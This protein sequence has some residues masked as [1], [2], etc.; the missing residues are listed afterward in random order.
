MGSGTDPQRRADDVIAIGSTGRTDDIGTKHDT[1][2]A[3][4]RNGS[5]RALLA[6]SLLVVALRSS[7]G[8][9][10]WT[11]LL[12]AALTLALLGPYEWI[13]H[14]CLLHAPVDSARMQRLGIGRGHVEHHQDPFEIRWLMLCWIEALSCWALLG[15]QSALLALP[16]AVVTDASIAALALSFWSAATLG[17]LHYEW[18]HLL[19][20]TRYRCRTR[21]YRAL[22]RHHRL[23]HFRNER[24]WLGVTARTGDRLR[25]TM[26]D[27]SGV[28][29]SA[30]A[31]T[32]RPTSPPLTATMLADVESLLYD[33]SNDTRPAWPTAVDAGDR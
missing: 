20:H 9:F 32:L 2:R 10:H 26:P 6:V 30:T 31:K 8:P 17:L 19:V 22:Q 3:F 18:I 11:D 1:G 16:L 33:P 24:Y 29:R 12:A 14:R 5:G 23:H 7:A 15:L 28:K 27:R 13:I 25:G 21:Y 4:V